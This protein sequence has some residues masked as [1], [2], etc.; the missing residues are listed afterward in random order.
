MYKAMNIQTTEEQKQYILDNYTN[1]G[2]E[3]C[4]NVTGLSKR[5]IHKFC[6]K[7]KLK[8]SPDCKQII[9]VRNITLAHEL[10][11][12]IKRI[13]KVNTEQ[14][15]NIQT[16]EVAYILGLL[17]ADGYIYHP[18]RI[19]I[20]C[21]KD[22]LITLLPFFNKTGQWGTYFRHRVNRKEQMSILT[23]NK[24]LVNFLTQNDYIAKSEKS[25][26]KILSLIPDN[27]KHYWFRG[28]I[29]GDGCF[30][31]NEKNNCY[32]FSLASSYSQ[33]WT[34][35]E[36]LCDKLGIKASI[37]RRKQITRQGKENTSSII[38][39]TDRKSI[40]I[41][42]NYIYN[43]YKK[44]SMGLKRKYDKFMIIK[45]KSDGQE[46]KSLSCP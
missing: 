44:D 8:V 1:L 4:S 2:G 29:D 17:W 20:E 45:E 11:K 34:Y 23:S 28:I 16:P 25:A 21:I 18:H 13:Y 43:N 42:G 46:K 38:R 30:Y 27:L 36:I 37:A 40:T 7:H 6:S 35:F 15:I 32:Q 41:F 9:Q 5:Y 10:Q 24:T 22:D 39:I 26:D 33:D 14:F 12:S 31:I 19:E 3:H